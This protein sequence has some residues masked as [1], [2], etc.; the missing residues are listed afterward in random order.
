MAK[1]VKKRK[2]RKPHGIMPPPTKVFTDRKKEQS[3][4]LC[5]KPVIPGEIDN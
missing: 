5:R 1:K 3:K 4:A 2:I